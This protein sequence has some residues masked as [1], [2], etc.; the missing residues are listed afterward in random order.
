MAA[1]RTPFGKMGGRLRDLHPSDLL[2]ATAKDAF[3]AGNV[4]PALV[5]TANIGQVY[6]VSELPYIIMRLLRILPENSVFLLQVPRPYR[7]L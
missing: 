2:A 1:K 5:D 7:D 4:S 6:T 3:K